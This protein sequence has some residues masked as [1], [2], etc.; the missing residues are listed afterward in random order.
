VF[1]IRELIQTS[2]SC[3][4]EWSGQLSDGRAVYIRF[5]HAQLTI[6]AAETLDQAIEFMSIPSLIFIEEL[7]AKRSLDQQRLDRLT[8]EQQATIP[9]GAV[10]CSATVDDH[11]DDLFLEDDLRQ[12]TSEVLS[13]IEFDSAPMTE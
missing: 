5:R 2:T 11:H 4:S 6:T 1:S 13:W 3:P 10:I 7:L 12:A 9:G 8:A